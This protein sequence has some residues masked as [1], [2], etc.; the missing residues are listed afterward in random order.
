MPK[1]SSNI[2]YTGYRV[3]GDNNTGAAFEPCYR[4]G[5]VAVCVVASH[6]DLDCEPETHLETMLRD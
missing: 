3:E 6:L 1:V 4:L 2:R 5:V